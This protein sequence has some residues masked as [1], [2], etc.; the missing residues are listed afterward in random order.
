M[1]IKLKFIIETIT[2]FQEN[3]NKKYMV[4]KEKN[5]E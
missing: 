3:N 1:M 2:K 4:I 5:I